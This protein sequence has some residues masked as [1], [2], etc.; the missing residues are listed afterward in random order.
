MGYRSDIVICM[1]PE[2]EYEF[3]FLG[4]SN[5]EEW[6]YSREVQPD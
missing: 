2:K 4:I 1:T 6:P 3:K 5:A